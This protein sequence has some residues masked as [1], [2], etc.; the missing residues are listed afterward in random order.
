MGGRGIS[1]HSSGRL[2][3]IIPFRNGCGR[4]ERDS[5]VIQPPGRWGRRRSNIRFPCIRPERGDDELGGEAGIAVK[6]QTVMALK[7]AF[8]A[9][10]GEPA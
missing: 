7:A 9:M 4:S 5:F 10:A 8:Q 2:F 1:V 3:V 6:P